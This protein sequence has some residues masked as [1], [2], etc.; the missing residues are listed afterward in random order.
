MKAVPLILLLFGWA[1]SFGQTPYFPEMG[2]WEEKS[3]ASQN[4]NSA[5]LQEAIEFATSHE[6]TGSKDL[7][8]AI[9]KSFQNE[10]F[11]EIMGPTKHRGG[12][13]GV[14]IKNGYIV[15]KWGDVDRVDMTFSVTKSFLSTTA[16]LAMDKGMIGN[17]NEPVSH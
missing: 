1:I 9:L 10:P 16:L 14:I 3:P 15:S 12:P 13:A 2:K 4:L 5:R 17:V 11:H 8:Q 7:R 6:Y